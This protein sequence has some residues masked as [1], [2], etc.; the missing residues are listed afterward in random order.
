MKSRKNMSNKQIAELLEAVAAVYFL[1]GDKFFR[2]RTYEEAALSIKKITI[3]IKEVWKS[4][5]LEKIP[6]VGD[7]LASYLDELFKT[8]KVGHFEKLFSEYPDAMF[9]LLKLSGIGPKNALKLSRKLKL[10][11]SKNAISK[12]KEAVKMKKIR[13]IEGFGIES[14]RNI[15]ESIISKEKMSNTE[16]MLFPFAE[17]LAD[18]AISHLKKLEGITEIEAMGSFRRRSSTIGDLD[19]G[20][21][22]KN[23][24]GVVDFFVEAPFVK[25]V[26]AQGVN[27]A[28]I[29][30]KTD[31][32]IDLKVVDPS[33]WGSLLQHYTGSKDH[34]I[35]L[36]EFAISK[37]L[38]LSEHGI[39][40]G[41]KLLK[42]SEE[43]AFYKKLGMEF[44]PPELR[45]GSGEIS[46]ALKNR[47]PVLVEE[48]DIKGDLHIHSNFDIETRHDLGEAS[49]EDHISKALKKGYQYI[50]FS[51]HNPSI[52]KHTEKE[53]IALLKRKKELI[54][55]LKSSSKNNTRI[56]ILNSLE[57][58]IRPD[59]NLAIS[60]KAIKLL[61]FM[62]V[63]IHSSFLMQRKEMTSRVLKGLAHPK[64]LILGHP[65]G[66]LLGKRPPI[67][68]AWNRLFD[69]CSKNNKI[70]EIN[71]HPQRLDL[72]DTLV[73]KA[74]SEKIKLCINSDSHRL[75]EMDNMKYGVSVARRGWAQ[76]CDIINT[77]SYNKLSKI[78]KIK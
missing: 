68:L 21:A 47:L 60:E 57:V 12:L 52:S 22:S 54:D 37:D 41:K 70:L 32:Q 56:H 10:K 2:V 5:D 66:R 46:L 55:K 69:F 49:M 13:E 33:S 39:K 71:S 73:R 53:T 45:E 29:I 15:L 27:T 28:R 23:F 61:D 48:K 31:R 26:L 17:I 58:D 42:F 14:E 1:K 63:S 38:S 62:I 6:G 74:I 72:S 36:R 3:S 11:S 78:L 75:D 35:G 19:I 4:G 50:G 76:K 64:A 43:K 20:V 77:M 51:E 25:K 67:E 9:E 34:N 24:K 65:S 44:I 40:K 30:H 7:A 59:G 18:D 16:R 8:G